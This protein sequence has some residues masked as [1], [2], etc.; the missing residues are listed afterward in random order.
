VTEF[1]SRVWSWEGSAQGVKDMEEFEERFNFSRLAET[2][3]RDMLVCGNFLVGV[4]D[5]KPAPITEVRGV[6]RDVYGNIEEYWYYGANSALKKMGG[7][8]EFAHDRYIQVGRE[9]WGIGMAH[10]LMTTYTDEEGDV[11]KSAL[12]IDKQIVQDFARIYH[13]FAAPRSI[14]TFPQVTNPDDFNIENPNSLAARIKNMKPGDRLAMPGEAEIVTEPVDSQARFTDGVE[15]IVNSEVGAGLQ[16]SANRLITQPSAMADAR[17]ANEKD[18]AHL[19]GLMEK[20]RRF[21]NAEIIPR[22]TGSKVEFVWGTQD[23][24]EFDPQFV[25]SLLN[26]GVISK[27]EV[28]EMIRAIGTPLDDALYKQETEEQEQKQMDMMKVG[29][30]LKDKEDEKPSA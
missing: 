2:Y 30:S 13:K 6:K 20:F 23:D 9:A 25:L 29:S 5:W 14:W 1:V 3:A 16:T 24:F 17:E 4:S 12:D 26:A 10:A 15:K 8:K 27:G 18:D 28:R 21:V 22:V 7:P 19:L 11:T